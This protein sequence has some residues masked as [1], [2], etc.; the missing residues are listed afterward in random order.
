MLTVLMIID[1]I[2]AI[3]A[4]DGGTCHL[5]CHYHHGDCQNDKL[6]AL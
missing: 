5:V 1:A 2:V 6:I 4:G 3:G